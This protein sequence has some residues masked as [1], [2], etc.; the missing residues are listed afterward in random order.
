MSSIWQIE[1]FKKLKNFEVECT[2]CKAVL[3]CKDWTT[4]SLLYHLKK[5]PTYQQKYNDFKEN[6]KS[7]TSKS[8]NIT[9]DLYVKGN[10]RI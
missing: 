2:D 4:S 7:G 9:M 6:S 10:T 5:H 8:K 3:K 1:L